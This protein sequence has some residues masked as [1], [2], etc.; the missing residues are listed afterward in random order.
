MSYEQAPATA[1]LA[2]HCAFCGRPLVDA[3][4]A[5]TGVGPICREK[6]LVPDKVSP[7]ARQEGNKLIHRIAVLQKGEEVTQAV[8]RLKELGFSHVVKRINKRIKKR[9]PVVQLSYQYGRLYL[10]ANVPGQLWN[11]WLI[12]MRNVPGMRYEGKGVGNS[13]PMAQKRSVWNLLRRFFPGREAMGP[14]GEFLIP[15]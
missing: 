3:Q 8:A 5:E 12:S 13:F 2:T 11:K 9:S 1:M 7:E 6:H 15:A 14:K 10:K 4:S